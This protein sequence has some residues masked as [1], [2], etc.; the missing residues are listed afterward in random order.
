MSEA[1][2][3]D[4]FVG[5]LLD[6]TRLDAGVIVPKREAV[7][8]GDLISTT[9]RRAGTV[10][11]G[12]VVASVV[13]PDLP[14]LSL[15]FVLAEQALFNILDNAA[16]YSAPGGRI[17]VEGRRAIGRNQGGPGRDRRA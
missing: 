13:A 15:D 7:E 2:R 4:R 11:K 10:L 1:E 12:R 8:V 9:L 16:K 14:T 6:M 17:D 5:N 3:L